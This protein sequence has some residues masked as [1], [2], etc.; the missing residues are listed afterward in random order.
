MEKTDI[1]PEN[2]FF[3]SID[4]PNEFFCD[5]LQETQKLIEH[6]KNGSNIVLKAPRRIG[7]S[8]LIKHLFKQNSIFERY[9][10]LF[11]D[12]YG[13]KNATDFHAEFQNQLLSA[14][15]AKRAKIKRVFEAMVKSSYLELGNYDTNTGKVSFPKIGFTPATLPKIPLTDLFD[16][17][18]HTE[19]PCLVVF[20]EFQQIQEYPERMAAILRGHIQQM[21]R[22]RFIF[23]GSSRHMLATMFQLS[24]QPFY[25]SA[26]PMDLDILSADSYIAFCKDMFNYGDKTVSDEAVSFVYN[27][28]SGETYLM[29]ETMKEAYARTPIAS[30]CEKSTI[31]DSIGELL[32]RKETDYRDI[33]NRL[34][35]KKERNT[36]I[37]IAMEGIATGLTSSAIMKKYQ[38]DNASSVQNALDNLGPVKMSLIESIAKGTYVIQDRLFEL[39]IASKTGILEQ[40]FDSAETRFQQQRDLISSFNDVAIR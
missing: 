27:L 35:N 9:N 5:R 2:P 36:L 16:Y 32:A 39:W 13:T 26:V 7:K 11:V 8:S 23:S 33:F 21:S 34:N 24:N 17:L 10:T 3:T 30:T 28:F 15:F 25:K 18:E 1:K 22:T 4:I 29:Q 20:D 14:P 6:I 19:K 38:L 37:C 31:L 40:K 12:I